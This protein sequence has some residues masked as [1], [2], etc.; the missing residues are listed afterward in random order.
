[1]FEILILVF[2][3]ANDA[4]YFIR[5]NIAIFSTV[6]TNTKS[7]LGQFIGSIEIVTI[8]MAVAFG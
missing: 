3:S 2:N 5:A 4:S 6:F 7:I 8:F 1:M